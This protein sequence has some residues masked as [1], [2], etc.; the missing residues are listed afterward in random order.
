MIPSRLRSLAV[1]EHVNIV[2]FAAVLFGLLHTPPSTANLVGFALLALLLGQGGTYWWLKLRQ[3]RTR[4]PHPP[5]IALLGALCHLNTALFALGGI[6][7]AWSG[8][9]GAHGTHL[10]PGAALWAFALI[11]HLNYFHLQLSHQNRADLA[12]LRRTR[13]LHRSHLARDLARHRAQRL[14][15]R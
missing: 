13:R 7:I 3:L 1:L 8:A 2:L 11:E 12:R 9:Q 15:F 5:G 4:A 6:L 10:W 14:S